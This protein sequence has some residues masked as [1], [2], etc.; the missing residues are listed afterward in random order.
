M[1]TRQIDYI[2]ED[3]YESLSFMDGELPVLD[4]V[5]ELFYEDG[6]MINMSF[7]KPITYSIDSFVRGLEN[8]INEG[9][10]TQF[11]QRELYSK[12]KVFGRIAQRTSVYEYSFAYHETENIPKGVNYIQFIQVDDLWRISS[13]IWSDEGANFKVPKELSGELF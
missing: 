5:R 6:L 8:Q 10:L 1:N 13:M 12:T 7:G 2:T 11:M 4:A 3:F 9:E